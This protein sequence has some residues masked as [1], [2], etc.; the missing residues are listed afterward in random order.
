M[1]RFGLAAGTAAPLEVYTSTSAE[2]WEGREV[3]GDNPIVRR[4]KEMLLDEA[5]K[6]R[7]AEF[8]TE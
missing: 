8:D 6:L 3:A 1:R 2:N 4:L 5:L 7:G